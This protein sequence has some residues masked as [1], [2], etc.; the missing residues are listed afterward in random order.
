LLFVVIM[1]KGDL[2]RSFIASVL[3]MVLVIYGANLDAPYLTLTLQD[4]GVIEQGMK[5]ANTTAGAVPY[6]WVFAK[7]WSL[8]GLGG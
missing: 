7:I 4:Q 8:L 3:I 2:L 6:T 1:N 5:V